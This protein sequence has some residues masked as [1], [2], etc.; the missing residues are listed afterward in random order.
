MDA[1]PSSDPLQLAMEH[2]CRALDAPTDKQRA[3]L[4]MRRAAENCAAGKHVGCDVGRDEN[5]GRM[6]IYCCNTVL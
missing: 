6:C 4:A 3:E 1:I 2:V 5:G